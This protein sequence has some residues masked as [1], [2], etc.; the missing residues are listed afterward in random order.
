M[1][2]TCETITLVE[3]TE[4]NYSGM[5]AGSTMEL[6]VSEPVDLIDGWWWELVV[7]LY[8]NQIIAARASSMTVIVEAVAPSVD[9]P[10]ADFIGGELARIHLTDQADGSLLRAAVALPTPGQCRVRLAMTRAG[11]KSSPDGATIGID[12]VRHFAFE[13]ASE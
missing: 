2:C 7:R 8:E 5:A 13:E 11:S 3:R 10:E 12:L 1:G 9:E 4:Y 6:V